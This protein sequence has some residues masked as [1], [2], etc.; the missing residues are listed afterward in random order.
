MEN[1]FNDKSYLIKE[2][3]L[4]RQPIA[5]KLKSADDI[6]HIAL[7]YF[8]CLDILKNDFDNAKWVQDYLTKTFKYGKRIPKPKVHDTDL[9]FALYMINEKNSSQLD[10]KSKS[11]FDDSKLPIN[12][13]IMW[14]K[15]TILGKTTQNIS[16]NLHLKL[17]SN[18][19]VDQSDY[20]NLQIM[21][22]NWDNIQT[23]QRKVVCTRI[24]Q[25]LKSHMRMSEIYPIFQKFVSSNKL[26]MSKDESKKPSNN[27]NVFLVG[28]G[29]GYMASNLANKNSKV[30]AYRERLR[31]LLEDTTAANIATVTTPLGQVVSRYG[32]VPKYGKRKKKTIFSH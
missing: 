6:K 17:L 10:Q 31:S 14:S 26:E 27:M 30:D 32:N 21:I 9:H 18:I 13:I 25:L 23:T 15:N 19:K 4:F 16:R 2:S 5:L 22:T 1:L 24:M 3:R 20:R 11:S 28:L 29:L 8:F 7:L 12:E